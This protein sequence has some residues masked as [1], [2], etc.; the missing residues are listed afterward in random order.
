MPE[1]T[2]EKF[3]AIVKASK[4]YKTHTSVIDEIL[5]R[6]EREIFVEEEPLKHIAFP[7]NN[8]QTSYYS[9]NCTSKDAAFID[10]F[11]Q[12]NGISPLN[13]RLFKSQ[14]GKSYNLRVCSKIADSEK[15]P[16]LKKY[17]LADGIT[18][19]VTAADFNTFMERVVESLE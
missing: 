12:K 16:Y 9:S 2:P 18:V 1:L 8:G 4:A 7:D 17:E 6:T 19:D 10:E 11:C 5:T 14:D 15:T 3:K 13:T